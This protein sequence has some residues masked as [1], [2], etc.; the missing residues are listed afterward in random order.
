[1]ARDVGRMGQ[2]HFASWCSSSGLSAN[3][4]TEDMTGWDVVV[5]TPGV[6]EV[7]KDGE[8]D[9]PSFTC[10]VQVKAS[11]QDNPYVDIVL[12]KL[13]RL[14]TDAYPAFVVLIQYSGESYPSQVYIRHIDKDLIRNV[15]KRIYELEQESEPSN[16]NRRKL[17]VHFDILHPLAQPHGETL[18]HALNKHVSEGMNTYVKDKMNFI[19]Q[20]GHEEGMLN[21]HVTISGEE[22]IDRM[23]D[24]SV[25]V[26]TSYEVGHVVGHQVRFG[27]KRK[28]P[29]I[30]SSGGVL[31]IQPI[32]RVQAILALRFEKYS[33]PMLFNVD[34]IPSPFNAVAPLERHLVRVCNHFLDLRINPFTGRTRFFVTYNGHLEQDISELFDQLSL[35]LALG[36][37][38]PI[39]AELRFPDGES[40][41]FEFGSVAPEGTDIAG[42]V[43]QHSVA[44][45]AIEVLQLCNWR[46]TVRI[47]AHELLANQD[48]ILLLHDILTRQRCALYSEFSLDVALDPEA[49]PIAIHF[50]KSQIGSMVANAI[51]TLSGNC[52]SIGK[53]RYA[54]EGKPT[55]VRLLTHESHKS[56][57][58]RD[59]DAIVEEIES[60]NPEAIYVRIDVN[61]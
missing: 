26:Q 2:H 13:W 18:A 10:K 5:E 59:I 15:L 35:F 14:A 30:S 1:M 55:L 47:S 25:G 39:I 57:D 37:G 43:L 50:I 20:V 28:D 17:R 19:K 6:A 38:R 16:L 23:F 45:L 53:Q 3:Q 51:V 24:Q 29:M 22:N 32:H 48:L 41:D 56:I 61:S 52:R 42:L 7:V 9:E 58:Q 11:D 36:K 54:I 34:C 60:M 12:D 21:M 46:S 49:S 4:S 27:V 31:E 40:V 8:I 33:A 44:S